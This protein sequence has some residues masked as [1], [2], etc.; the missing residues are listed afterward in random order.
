MNWKIEDTGASTAALNMR[1]DSLLL[2]NG[3]MP[4][5]HFYDWTMP[6]A[7]YGYFI[8]PNDFFVSSTIDVAKRPTGGGILF[9][10]CDFT[11]SLFIPS[12]HPAYSTNTLQNYATINQAVAKAIQYFDPSLKTTLL[13]S[14]VS[15]TYGSFCMTNPTIYD[16]LISG[17]KVGGAAQRRTKE[18][19]LHQGTIALTHPPYEWISSLLKN[20]KALI[21]QMESH[22]FPL[23]KDSTA[24][25]IAHAKQIL[26]EAFMV[27]IPE[28]IK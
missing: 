14:E 24:K 20:G 17:K 9:H 11:F 26:K 5:L 16:I 10:I 12:S 1:Y 13:A 15:S 21:S 27:I 25:G 2:Q 23:L 19:I 8:N 22:T 6:S 3:Q 18:G 28:C 4:T 7:T